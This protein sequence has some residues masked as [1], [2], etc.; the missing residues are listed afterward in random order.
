MRYKREVKV[1]LFAFA[2]LALIIWATIKVGDQTAISRGS[3][4][5]IATFH[6]ASGLYPKASVEIA[7]VNVGLIKKVGL[8][9]NGLAKAVMGI[10][11]DVLI[12]ENSK[13]FLRVRGF[14]GEA[15]I[16]IIPGDES[17][18]QLKSGAAIADT[19]SGGDISDMVDRFN[20]ISGDVKKITATVK[21]WTGFDERGHIRHSVENL[22]EF[23]RVMRNLSVQNEKSMNMIIRNMADLTA[24]L[25][26]VVQNNKGNIN[27]SSERIAS[28]SKK[29]DEGRGTIGRLINDG[30]TA[31][32]LNRSLDNLNEALGGFKNLEMGLGFHTEYLNRSKDFKNYVS[33]EMKPT[34]N[35]SVLLDLINDPSPDTVRIKKI[36]DITVGSTTTKVTTE[37]ELLQRDRTLFSA[38]LAKYFYDFR[39]RG[40]LIE[41][42]GGLGLDYLPGFLG[43]HFDAFDFENDFNERPHLKAMGTVNLTQNIFLLSGIDDPLN[44]AQ[45]TDFFFGGG[46][47]FVDENIKSLFGL[48]S[49]RGK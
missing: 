36:S 43:L 15:Y 10:Q 1:G 34:P 44:P 45:K 24:D 37:N 32:K 33:V 29:I 23:V 7:G 20:S 49:L 25:K 26:E 48:A 19:E 35:E 30:E 17:L 31:E 13:A 11:K 16:E 18:P 39:I 22:D 8:T 4:E 12:T 47:R 46:F 27:D 9:R 21:D 5:L 28:I 3:Y 38:Q 14:L 41:S 6:N 2:A 42:K 40:G